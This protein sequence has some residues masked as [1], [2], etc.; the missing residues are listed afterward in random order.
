MVRVTLFYPC[1][2]AAV[3]EMASSRLPP[4]RGRARAHAGVSG[5]RR[6]VRPSARS[7]PPPFPTR[8]AGRR[9]RD[10]RPCK[11]IAGQSCENEV[12]WNGK[13]ETI[14]R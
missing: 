5:L 13:G 4:E 6:F 12:G 2:A 3:S 9:E 10:N 7:Q 14:G 1:P 11:E 8:G